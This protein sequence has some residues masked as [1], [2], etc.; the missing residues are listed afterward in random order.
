M[1]CRCILKHISVK[2]TQII[3]ESVWRVYKKNISLHPLLEIE[4]CFGKC[5]GAIK[6]ICLIYLVL[7]KRCIIFALAFRNRSLLVLGSG[8]KLLENKLQN[9][10]CLQKDVLPLHPLSEILFIYESKND[11]LK[12][13]IHVYN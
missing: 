5:F 3:L 10:W 1:C 2:L 12:T 4:A 8:L 7:T 13:Y 9:I 6:N 11:L